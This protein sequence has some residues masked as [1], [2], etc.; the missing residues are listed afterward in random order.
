MID[1]NEKK[2]AFILCVNDEMEYSECRYYLDMLKIPEGYET[3]VIIVQEAESMTAGYNAGMKGSDA[4]YKVYL[5]QDVF[6]KNPEFIADMLHVFQSDSKIGLMGC[7]GA[8]QLGKEARAVTDWDTGKILHNCI[9]PIAEFP[10]EGGICCEA[11]AV[12]GLLI[13][14]QYDISWRE[15]IF[16]GWDFYDISQCMEFQRAGY[17]IVVPYQKEPWC[18]HDNQ[19]SKMIKYEHYRKLFVQEY[20]GFTELNPLEEHTK[21]LEY[22]KVKEAARK[23]IAALIEAGRKNDL[24]KIFSAQENRGYLHLREYEAITCIDWLEEENRSEIHFWDNSMHLIKLLEKLRLLK[25]TLKRIEYNVDSIEENMARLYGK[26]SWIAIKEVCNRYVGYQEK[27]FAIFE[28][29]NKKYNKWEIN[30]TKNHKN[31]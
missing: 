14:T 22:E 17:K 6:I 31:L 15:D 16:D 9:P 27:V 19:Y 26:Y 7:I 18:Y 8:R 12:D 20:I 10:P 25:Y 4:K 28:E 1:M 13:A 5:H 21:L 29:Y 30:I 11:E 3:D 23:E 24:R 2:V